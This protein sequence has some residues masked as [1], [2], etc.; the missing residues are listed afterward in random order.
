MTDIMDPLREGGYLEPYARYA[1]HT[2]LLLGACEAHQIP[3]G[4]DIMLDLVEQW[5][6]IQDGYVR[7]LALETPGYY[8]VKTMA[9]M[10]LEMAAEHEY[11]GGITCLLCGSADPNFDLVPFAVTEFEHSA[12][13]FEH[14]AI[15]L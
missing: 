13:A 5:E 9:T 15:R 11:T 14:G 1:Q 10:T 12:W 4:S 6:Y 8:I 2:A 3:R 7:G